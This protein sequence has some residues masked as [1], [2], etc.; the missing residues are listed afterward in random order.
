[1]RQTVVIIDFELDSF[2]EVDEIE[3]HFVWT[4]RER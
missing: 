1:M 2:L 3:L 4:V